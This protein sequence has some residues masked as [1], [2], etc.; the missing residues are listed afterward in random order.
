MVSTIINHA[1]STSEVHRLS[2]RPCRWIPKQRLSNFILHL[3]HDNVT[4]HDAF[5][6]NWSKASICD[7]ALFISSCF[8]KAIIDE[9]LWLTVKERVIL[10]RGIQD[11]PSCIAFI[12]GTLEQIC[13]L[14]NNVMYW[15]WFNG[16][17]KIYLM[18]N[19]IL[20]DNQDLF[21][22]IDIRYPG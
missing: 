21:I 17:K 18:D 5:M 4:M 14:W 8:N 19:I 15:T 20:V 11:F 12:N 2:G 6:W 13:K 16:R 9:I 22:Y 10:V 1:K 7:D 3:K